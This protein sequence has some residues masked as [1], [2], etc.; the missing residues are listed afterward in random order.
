MAVSGPESKSGEPTTTGQ[1][2]NKKDDEAKKPNTTTA[3]QQL[4]KRQVIPKENRRGTK[5]DFEGGMRTAELEFQQYLRAVQP[6]LAMRIAKRYW[7]RD[8][9]LLHRA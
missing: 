5:E 4:R 7:L 6:D 1:K 2:Q 9:P 3:L 8:G